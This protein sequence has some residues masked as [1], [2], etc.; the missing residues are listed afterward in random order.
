MIAMSLDEVAAAVEAGTDEAFGGGP[1]TGVS[2]DS[3]TIGPGDL[4]FAIRGDQFDGHDYVAQAVSRGAAACVVSRPDVTASAPCLRVDDTVAAMGRLAVHQRAKTRATVIAVTGSNGKT[5]T[6]RMID[7]VLGSRLRGRAAARS[8]NNNL[9][10]PLTLLSVNQ[11]DEYLVVEIGSNAPGEVGG[12]AAMASPQIGVVTSVGFAH[13]EGLGGI[14][15]VA[16]EKLSLLSHLE[17]GGLGVVNVDRPTTQA[18]LGDY[19]KTDGELVTFGLSDEADLRVGDVVGG[20]EGVRFR[21]DEGPELRLRVCGAHNALNAA[22]AYAVGR[23]MGL[24]FDEMAKSLASFE[25]A[26]MRLNVA[27]CGS[28]TVINDCYNANPS[29][30]AAA[31]EVLADAGGAR[32]VLVIGDMLELGT[33]ARRWHE[34]LG[35]QAGEAG[36]DLLVAVGSNATAVAAGAQAGGSATETLVYADAARAGEGVGD[37]LQPGDVVLVKGSRA[38]TMERVVEA[39]TTSSSVGAPVA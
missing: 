33:D 24:G 17:A 10:V 6:K 19:A 32:R 8:F 14:E 26:R 37:W 34:R 13:L 4:F 5:T 7:H 18:L 30:M 20:L 31:I 28:L 21:I 2:T 23:R 22:A 39:L 35:R 16:R 12:L 36:I 25:P 27:R 3:R 11:D 29:S 9:G 38:M 15:G 1:V